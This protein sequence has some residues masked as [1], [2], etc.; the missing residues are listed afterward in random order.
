MQV[1]RLMQNPAL[2]PV[3]QLIQTENGYAAYDPTV[4]RLHELN[5]TASLIVELCDGSRSVEEICAFL[6]PM[7]AEGSEPGVRSWIEQGVAAGLLTLEGDSGNAHRELSSEEL[8]KISRRLRHGNKEQIALIC[9]RQATELAP[10][11]PDMWY[12]LGELLQTMGQR[13]EARAAYEKYIGFKPDDAEIQHILVALRDEPAPPRASNEAMEQIYD[14]FA[15]SFEKNLCDELGYRAPERVR[16]LIEPL[17]GE[18][19]NLAVL[20]LGC[21]TG[22]AGVQFKPRASRLIG[23]DISPKMIELARARGLYDRLDVSEITAWLARNSERFE[24]V[25]CCDCLIYFGDL[26]QVAMPVAELLCPGG[27]FAFTLERGEQHP[28]RLADTGRYTHHPDH[29]RQAAAEAGLTVA[30][31]EEGFLRTEVGVPV[32]GLFVALEK[33]GGT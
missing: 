17:L 21:G 10:D 5:P 15:S 23:V 31:L 3:I 27:V 14:E 8:H 12:D 13:D 22:L 4:D 32:T 7:L 18:R 6:A 24:L 19:Q 16:E 1:H 26:R 30:R 2:K 11:N 20:D 29:V 33:G 25:V 28:L 9:Q